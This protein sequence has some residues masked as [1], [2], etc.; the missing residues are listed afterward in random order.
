MAV[1]KLSGFLKGVSGKTGNAVYRY[2]RNGTE[3]SDRPFVNNPQT[4]SQQSVRAAFSKATKGWRTLTTA[5]AAA[6]N[7][8]ASTILENDDI[9]G[10]KTKRSGFNWYVALSSRFYLVNGIA[11]TAP[12]TPPT[13]AFLGDNLTFTVL[14]GAGNMKITASAPNSAGTTTALL[15]QKLSSANGKAQKN[16]YRT[17]THFAFASGSLQATLTLPP[18]VYSVAT[19]YVNTATG[20]ETA[21]NVLG[22]FGP[23]TFM[24][25]QGDTSKKK[26]A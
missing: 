14:A 3:L 6:W 20:Q 26:A 9:S 25:M 4:A 15:V 8:F 19:Q 21:L 23:V 7:A 1:L 17:K 16:A 24:V 22:T 12:T 11:G 18:G 2:T 13:T 5:Q 10:N